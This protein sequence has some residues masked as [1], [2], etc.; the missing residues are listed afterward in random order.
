VSREAPPFTRCG[1][2]TVEIARVER[3][4]RDGHPE[5]LSRV[6]AMEELRDAG[7]GADRA[8][9]LAARF[10]AKEACLKLFPREA[11]LGEVEPADFVVDR[12]GYGAPHLASAAKVRT[13]L[14][15][16][17]LGGIALSMSHD[18]THATAV[19]VSEPAVTGVPL[20]GRF[21][22][23]C[24]PIRRGVVLENLRR[25]FTGVVPQDEIVRLAQAFYAHVATSLV[26]LVRTPWLAAKRRAALVRLENRDVAVRAAEREKGLLLLTG[27]LGNWELATV[28]A[29]ANEPDFRGRFHVLRRPVVPRALDRFVNRR[30]RRAGL[31]VIPKLGGLPLILDR[32]AANDAV[33]FVLDQ[34]AGARDGV[35][36]DF[37]GHPAATFR[38]LAV[39]ALATGAPVLP[40]ATWR[41]PDG[42]HVLR[43]EE[44][45]PTIEHED[46]NEAIRRNTRAYNAALERM[47]LEHPEQ[48]FWMHRRWKLPAVPPKN[49]S[50]RRG[51]VDGEAVG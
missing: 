7:D 28:N 45:L 47:I 27:H 6:F 32:L 17:R 46:T 19:A 50:P 11:A 42:T 8:A 33:V 20:S 31:G 2:D 37:F 39:V 38:S 24:L 48:W 49:T 22:Y 14:G 40:I 4:L 36:V 3:W 10:A 43:F 13:L 44:P 30:F 21:L 34:H 5:D 1:I 16:Y 25:V 41:E 15:R 23:H 18:R 9:R 26:E 12:D 51:E 29:I 35:V